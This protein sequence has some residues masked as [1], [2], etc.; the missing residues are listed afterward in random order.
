MCSLTIAIWTACLLIPSI[1]HLVGRAESSITLFFATAAIAA[2]KK[3]DVDPA[4]PAFFRL[5]LTAVAVKSLSPNFPHGPL[6]VLL[7]T[8]QMVSAQPEIV[9]SSVAADPDGDGF[10]W[11]NNQSCLVT[12]D[13][14]SAP[15][16]INRETGQPV[17]LVRAIWNCLLYTS[18]SPRDKRQSRMP[19]SA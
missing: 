5:A 14:D 13:S 17:A 6:A 1:A 4:M 11:E 15:Q 3:F 12:T 19:S 18:P 16:F 2:L 9:C 10:G 7:L 8:T